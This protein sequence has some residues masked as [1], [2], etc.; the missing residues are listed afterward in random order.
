[1]ES[2]LTPVCVYDIEVDTSHSYTVGL[3][4][5]CVHNCQTYNATGVGTPMFTTVQKCAEDGIPIIADGGIR[6]VGDICKA[7]VAGASMVMVGSLFAQCVD[8][9]AFI[10]K[11]G[12]KIYFG[13]ASA[14]NGVKSDF[15]EGTTKILS[16]SNK[17]YVQFYKQ[18]S[19]GITSCMSYAGVDNI[20]ELKGMQ[21]AQK[22][23]N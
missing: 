23:S 15:I 3:Q 4:N 6:E 22:T 8:S 14:A 16:T 9:P 2:T 21:W 10:D 11:D 12:N 7:L 5:I 1:M 20:K 13:S 19:D 18:I 17:T